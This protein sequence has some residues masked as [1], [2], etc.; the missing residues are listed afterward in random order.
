[1]E[2][3]DDP[4][5]KE[6]FELAFAKRPAEELYDLRK[7]PDQLCNVADVPEYAGAKK[8]LASA[9]QAELIATND[10]RAL[11]TGDVFDRYPY[12]GGRQPQK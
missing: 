2:H 11:G 6:L 3:R 8:A 5:T 9:L 7:D 12:Y 10:P 1:M 4:G